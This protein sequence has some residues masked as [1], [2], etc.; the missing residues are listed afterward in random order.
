[1]LTLRLSCCDGVHAYVYVYICIYVYICKG[2]GP[3]T[4]VDEDAGHCG[5]RSEHLG[6]VPEREGLPSHAPQESRSGEEPVCY[7][8]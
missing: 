2:G 7:E 8:G 6:Q 5:A 1:M 4:R 3:A